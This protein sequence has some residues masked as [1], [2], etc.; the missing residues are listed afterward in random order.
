MQN[1]CYNGLTCYLDAVAA[2]QLILV[3]ANSPATVRGGKQTMKKRRRQGDPNSPHHFS[4]EDDDINSAEDAIS[5]LSHGGKPS[6]DSKCSRRA[7]CQCNKC[8]PFCRPEIN[9]IS[10][11]EICTITEEDEKEHNYDKK[12]PSKMTDKA[13]AKYDASGNIII[14]QPIATSPTSKPKDDKYNKNTDD[15]EDDY[16]KKTR[17]IQKGFLQGREEAHRRQM[18]ELER[19]QQQLIETAAALRTST[20]FQLDVLG[21]R[22]QKERETAEARLQDDMATDVFRRAREYNKK[23]DETREE[24]ERERERQRRIESGMIELQTELS[25]NES[26]D[27]QQKHP[28]L[29]PSPFLAFAAKFKADLE[30]IQE[31]QQDQDQVVI[32]VNNETPNQQQSQMHQTKKKFRD[33]RIIAYL[34]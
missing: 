27:L 21:Q 29:P 24:Q 8:Q 31:Q 3:I 10:R 1:V 32:S 11:I 14:A 18:A 20:Q 17:K 6:L 30:E 2:A 23:Q 26:Q 25:P 28:S 5:Q 15:D 33:Q 19:E 13:E 34:N 4:S 16:H 22:Q 12:R 9:N 7:N